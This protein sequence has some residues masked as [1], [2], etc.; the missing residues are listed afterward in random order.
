MIDE[1]LDDA[2][3]HM[4]LSIEAL[5]NEFRSIR[6]GRA[7]PALVEHIPVNYYG[8]PTPLIKLAVISIPEPRLIAIR[9]FS[10]GDIGEVEK[11]ILRSDLGITPSNDGQIVRLSIPPLTEERRR[12]LVRQVGK[13]T[14]DAR[15]AIRN[16][17]RSANDLLRD[18]EKE[19]IISEDEM[20][21]GRDEVQKL[22]KTMIERVDEVGAAKEKEIMEI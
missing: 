4:E 8:S 12:E 9:P 5:Q 10:A 14:E 21:W 2:R 13:R 1:I 18:A 11:A 6:T 3:S 15:V 20:Y 7:T 19:K 17:R 16:I 22:V